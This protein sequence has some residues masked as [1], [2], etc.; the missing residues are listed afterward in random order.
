MQTQWSYIYGVSKNSSKKDVY[1]YTS[2]FKEIIKNSYENL[3]THT[4]M[5]SMII[6]LNFGILLIYRI[7]KENYAI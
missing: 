6:I 3:C 2:L 7:S 4:C 5:T 1:S